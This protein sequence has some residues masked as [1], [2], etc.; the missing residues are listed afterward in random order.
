MLKDKLIKRLEW[1]Y[2]TERLNAWAS[3]GLMLYVLISYE[4]THT[5]FLLYGLLLMSFILFQGQYYWKLKLYRLKNTEIDQASNLKLFRRCKQINVMMI[6][7]LPILLVGQWLI[8]SH[9]PD[10][11][12]FLW[13][14]LASIVGILEHINYYHRQL[15]IDNLPDLKYLIRYRRLKIAS[16]KKDLDENKL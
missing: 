7:F 9:T 8:I 5:F 13:G 16:L 6:A 11:H 4:P 2:P 1:Y 3:V 14:L 12:L 15:M 10:T